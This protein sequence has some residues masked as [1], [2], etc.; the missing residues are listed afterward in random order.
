MLLYKSV[1][2]YLHYTLLFNRKESRGNKKSIVK[3]KFYLNNLKILQ[4]V[5]QKLLQEVM[6]K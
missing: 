5:L 3:T 2:M 1:F 6:L 4:S